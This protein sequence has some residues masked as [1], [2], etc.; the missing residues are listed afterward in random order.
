[1]RCLAVII[2][3]FAVSLPAQ[4]LSGR[5]QSGGRPL[6]GARITLFNADT[7]DFREVRSAADGSFSF[8]PAAGSFRLGAAYPGR[9]YL[10]SQVAGGDTGN[11]L[12]LVPENQAGRW[13]IILSAAPEALG[14][15]NSAVLLPD[16]RI[17]YCHNTLDPFL[18]HPAT[19][20][21]SLVPPSP[22]QQ[23]CHAATLLPDG[24]IIYV[25]GHDAGVYGP[26]TR[27]VKTLNAA[28]TAW[29]VQ[30]DLK[31]YRWYPSMIQ[32]PD[33]GLLAV[34]GGNENN[35][36]RSLT[37][38]TMDPATL[39]WT[40]A[41]NIA[42]G[43][44]V[45]PIALLYTGEVLM[46]HR[47]PQLYDPGTRQWRLAG[48][49]VQGPRMPDGDH[50]DH[51]LVLMPN[52]EA[53][54]IGC[55]RF[56]AGAPG[57]LVEIYDPAADSWRLGA[58]FPPLRSRPNVALLPDRKILVM[59][60]KKEEAAD[61]S[62]VNAWEQLRLTDA[63][64]PAADSWRRLADMKVAREYHA[65]PV[66]VPDGR[67]IM[68]AGE[69][70][71]GEEPAQSTLEAFSPPYLFRGV[72][73]RIQNLAQTAFSRGGT[74]RFEVARTAAP[75]SVILMSLSANT[76][77]MES[78]NNR[79]LELAFTRNGKEIAAVLP[80][81]PVRLPHGFYT[82]FVLVDDIPSQ[83]RILRID[84]PAALARTRMAGRP[85][86]GRGPLRLGLPDRPYPW[87]PYGMD[88]RKARAWSFGQAVLT[89]G[90]LPGKE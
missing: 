48:D 79:Y 55:I 34:G 16:G 29:A 31:G 86:A 51:D 36:Q 74:L 19:G 85:R 9:Q 73:P 43:N 88:G 3:L 14:G 53:V 44:E 37:S 87:T 54:A 23:G 70:K 10:E 8:S 5:V 58:N 47:P 2:G 40:Y 1:M 63:Y 61:P 30:P 4:T 62:P 68:V 6:A 35:P 77:F 83:G 26:G 75:T 84:A 56:P 25:G 38:E 7:S 41:G 13:D 90:N 17:I 78:G 65:T 20:G 76:H 15:T 81:D 69:G 49:F 57:N 22:R 12:E 59:G 72:R 27:Q 18:F 89:I 52:G 50:S 45:S 82:L 24:R 33:G 42:V 71:P 80:T 39:Q 67:V 60:G 64:D 11:T 32:L 21:T 66:L 28:A 46:T